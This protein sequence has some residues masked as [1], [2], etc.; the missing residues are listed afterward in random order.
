[1]TKQSV[2]L[3]QLVQKIQQQLAPKAQVSHNVHMQGRH[4]GRKR[5]VDVLVYEKVGQ[6]D[7]NIVIDC[8]DY[9]KPID[10]KGVEEFAGLL[11]DVGAQ[12]GVLVC[13]SGFS[14]AAKIR[15]KGLQ[16]D[17]YSP[18]DTDP[19]KW[20]VNPFI[21]ATCE[22]KLVSF[23]FSVSTSAP[24]P[25]RIGTDFFSANDVFDHRGAKLG[26]AYSKMAQRWNEGEFLDSLDETQT[27]NIF[28]DCG[29]SVDNG[30]GQMCPVCLTARLE[31]QSQLFLGQLPI[32]EMSGFKDELS[33]QIITNAFTVGILDPEVIARDWH[34]IN[35]TSDLKAKAVIHLQGLV[36][37]DENAQVEIKF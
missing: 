5:Q 24:L 10:V 34:P 29:V 33:G 26:T 9:K 23:G 35:D 25:F 17:L 2:L 4:T 37:W 18:I 16:I 21:P 32:S 11:D 31:L 28:G 13:P 3:E 6:Y 22:F 1:M 20:Q 19:H 27:I 14:E 7:I 12:K 36:C 15:A 30:Y 8:K